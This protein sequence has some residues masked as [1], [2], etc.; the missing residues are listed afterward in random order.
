MA[1][2]K[3]NV[4][5]VGLSH[6]GGM[7]VPIYR[8][9]PGVGE[10]VVSDLDADLAASGIALGASRALP[11]LGAVLADDSIDVVHLCTPPFMHGEM[12]I[13]VLEAGKHCAS[14]VPAAVDMEHLFE[15]VRLQESTGKNYMMMETAV[16]YSPTLEV[17]DLIAQGAFGELT[18]GRGAHFQDMT[19][20]P[21]YWQGFPPHHYITHAIGPLLTLLDTRATSVRCLGSGRLP[22]SEQTRWGNPFPIETAIF[23]LEGSD[24]AIEVSRSMS[25]MPRLFH[26]GFS[27]Y[28]EK[29]GYEWTSWGEA[30]VRYPWAPGVLITHAESDRR[31]APDTRHLLPPEIRGDVPTDKLPYWGAPLHLVHELISSIAEG[32]RSFIDAVRA[33]DMTGAGIAAHASA[34]AGGA[35]VEIPDF[36]AAVNPG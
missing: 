32:R 12:A 31:P 34:M 26:E 16:Y 10:I 6:F 29:L 35:V 7:F 20:A 19:D 25:R 18:F 28:G 3:V 23:E 24:V 2:S 30:P 27:L 22:E 4:A 1:V 8:N 9:H 5:V 33:A 36:R 14:A 21:A 13:Q 17:R 15:I 11:D